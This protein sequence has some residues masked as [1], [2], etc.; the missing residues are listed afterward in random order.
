MNTVFLW[1]L[2]VIFYPGSELA[3]SVVIND[4]AS[5]DE[6]RRLRTEVTRMIGSSNGYSN[7]AKCMQYKTVR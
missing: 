2:V 5:L 3:H 4:L 6:C 7:T 1:A